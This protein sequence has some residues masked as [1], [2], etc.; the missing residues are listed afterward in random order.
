[1]ALTAQEI[2]DKGVGGVLDQMGFAWNYDGE[3]CVYRAPDGCK[4]VV[5]HLIPEAAYDSS[6]EGETVEDPRVR[7]AAGIRKGDEE[8]ARR[9]Q[10]I[11]DDYGAAVNEYG[12]RAGASNTEYLISFAK[13]AIVVAEEFGIDPK[14]AVEWLERQAA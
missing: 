2:F 4:C 12:R 5:G 7:D 6:L 9:L 11:H 13:D 1:M 14:I 10:G 8:L 3:Y